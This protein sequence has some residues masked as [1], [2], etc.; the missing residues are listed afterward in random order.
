[1]STQTN[2]TAEQQEILQ[3]TWANFRNAAKAAPT[4]SKPPVE[5]EHYWP[6][7]GFAG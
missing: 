1:M 4:Q 3:R 5:P 6:E 2:R 7:P